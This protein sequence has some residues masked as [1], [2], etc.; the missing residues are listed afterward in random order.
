MP[1]ILLVVIDANLGA[2][3][4][5][6]SLVLGFSLP[7]SKSGRSFIKI[8]AGINPFLIHSSLLEEKRR[9][10]H[11]RDANLAW[12][13]LVSS[14]LAHLPALG[15]PLE[16]KLASST[17][18]RASGARLKWSP[19]NLFFPDYFDQTRIT[20]SWI[21]N[22][23]ESNALS[24]MLRCFT[25]LDDRCLWYRWHEPDCEPTPESIDTCFECVLGRSRVRHFGV[26]FW[27][28]WLFS[29]GSLLTK[30]LN[31]PGF[32]SWLLPFL[33]QVAARPE[34]ASKMW[35]GPNHWWK[36]LRPSRS[37]ASGNRREDP[38]RAYYLSSKCDEC[39]SFDELF[40]VGCCDVSRFCNGQYSR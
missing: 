40:T 18:S 25:R 39:K 26:V 36:K 9:H 17:P 20:F 16:L 6:C 35:N 13:E 15:W 33:G 12:S 24:E 8:K 21:E 2:K 7:L 22:C 14:F 37:D 38:N 1:V 29:G 34:D 19:W 28:F 5:I 31:D 27:R 23:G 4:N 11:H 32:N 3:K 10:W 30:L